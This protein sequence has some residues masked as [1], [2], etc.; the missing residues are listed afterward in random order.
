M[1]ATPNNKRGVKR[2]SYGGDDVDVV[3]IES[4]SA[5][6]TKPNQFVRVKIEPEEK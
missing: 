6:I 5:S 1:V 4:G 2:G 3:E